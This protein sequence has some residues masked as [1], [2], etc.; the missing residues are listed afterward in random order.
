MTQK[1]IIETAAEKVGGVNK[2][3]AL[4]GVNRSVLSSYKSERYAIGFENLTKILKVANLKIS[5]VCNTT[6]K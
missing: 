1:E 5:L 6:Q 2:L 3:A 4:S